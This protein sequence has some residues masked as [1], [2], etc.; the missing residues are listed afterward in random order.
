MNNISDIFKNNFKRIK[1]KIFKDKDKRKL[2]KKIQ[3]KNKQKP[4]LPI[5]YKYDK[6]GYIHEKLQ[7]WLFP[8]NIDEYKHI[9]N[10]RILYYKHVCN[11]TKNKEKRIIEPYK[12][13]ICYL[14]NGNKKFE[15]ISFTILYNILSIK[16]NKHS[17]YEHIYN[18]TYKYLN[19][20]KLIN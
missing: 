1:L 18:I 2:Q 7:V 16:Y 19:I 13:H 10:K 11:S 15:T 8:M 14:E 12:A 4:M 17:I 6:V 3:K 9:Y 5:T 20:H